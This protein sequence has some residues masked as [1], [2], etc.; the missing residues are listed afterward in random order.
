MRR[1]AWVC[2]CLLASCG[3]LAAE[4]NQAYLGI[5]AET[6]SQKMIGM[7][8]MPALPPDMDPAVLAQIPGVP[9]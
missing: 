4:E 8:E 3:A 7:P 9:R 2:V 1:S 6:R 5:F